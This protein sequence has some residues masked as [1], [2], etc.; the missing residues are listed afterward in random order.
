MRPAHEIADDLLGEEGLALADAAREY[1]SLPRLG[2][3]TAEHAL[4]V[5]I[6]EPRKQKD[7]LPVVQDV[8]A[9]R[10]RF[11]ALDVD[12]REARFLPP[13]EHERRR[14]EERR[15]VPVNVRK[16]ADDERVVP[17]GRVGL[18]HITLL[19][20][21]APDAPLPLFL[22]QRRGK[23]RGGRER[24]D[25]GDVE[26]G[27][28]VELDRAARRVEDRGRAVHGLLLAH[29][30]QELVHRGFRPSLRRVGRDV[31][32]VE[33]VVDEGG[34]RRG[35]E[36]AVVFPKS[37]VHAAVSAWAV[38]ALAKHGRD[39][40]GRVLLDDLVAEYVSPRHERLVM[41]DEHEHARV[42]DDAAVV[43]VRLRVPEAAAPRPGAKPLA[44]AVAELLAAKL[45]G[46]LGSY[47]H[48][49]ARVDAGALD[50]EV[51]R[52]RLK[53]VAGDPV[54]REPVPLATDVHVLE[55]G[56]RLLVEVAPPLDRLD[57][58]G[59]VL[60]EVGGVA[61]ARH[62]DR[63][64][65]LP[66]EAQSARDRA[67]PPRRVE[68]GRR[69]RAETVDHVGREHPVVVA[70]ETVQLDDLVVLGHAERRVLPLGEGEEGVV[71]RRRDGVL[72]LELVGRHRLDRL[73]NFVV[74]RLGD[75][76]DGVGAKVGNRKV[77]C[78]DSFTSRSS[79]RR[80]PRRQA[81]GPASIP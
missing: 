62:A 51:G 32:E 19:D 79:P 80:S 21:E 44:D 34:L 67:D 76:R 47:G 40:L 5:E 39:L 29:L 70:E 49:F 6:R 45:D 71:R 46:L 33:E 28:S 65:E 52:P 24:D 26:D 25:T 3:L 66:R 73:G 72:G 64:L 11:V 78:R 68:V 9:R 63:R 37:P 23:P 12:E 30:E 20:V 43:V 81:A 58:R 50:R 48:G 56:L 54:V 35:D 42:G 16:K 74:P 61:V 60:E 36:R 59:D 1:E 17:R 27:L 53:E 75:F 69:S 22:G 13:L 57:D 15:E 7:E 38:E 77:H 31:R 55:A 4:L 10:P 8:D 18:L 41:R 14:H 2:H